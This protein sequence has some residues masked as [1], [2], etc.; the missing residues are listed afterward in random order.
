MKEEEIPP[1][2]YV[3]TDNNSPLPDVI[4]QISEENQLK[5]D[6]VDYSH[7]FVLF[8]FMGHQ[9]VRGPKKEVTRIWQTDNII[10]IQANFHKQTDPTVIPG[11]TY[12]KE[13]VKVSKD[14]MSQFGEITLILLDQDGTQRAFSTCTIFK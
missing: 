8:M 5:L 11:F 3:M 4:T 14:N 13:A 1:Q 12:P 6:N 10:Y 7:N 9:N 2:I